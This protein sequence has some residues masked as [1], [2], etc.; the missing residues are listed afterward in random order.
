MYH[1]ILD[2]TVIKEK[3]KKKKKN[4]VLGLVQYRVHRSHHQAALAH[5]PCEEREREK[6]RGREREREK[7]KERER[8]RE[9][10]ACV[11]V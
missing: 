10:W 9:E 2:S 7:E 1:L 3:K 11:S 8:E 6:E 5:L 4:L